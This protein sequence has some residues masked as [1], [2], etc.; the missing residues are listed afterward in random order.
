M[1]RLLLLLGILMAANLF[2]CR[3]AGPYTSLTDPAAA[4]AD[5][6]RP[7]P[8]DSLQAKA[9]WLTPA[10]AGSTKAEVRKWNAS[11]R[12]ALVRAST[13]APAGKV[14]VRNAGNVTEK[15]RSNFTLRQREKLNQY[16]RSKQKLRADNRDQTQKDADLRHKEKPVVKSG[17]K[18]PAGFWIALIIA[19]VAWLVL[20]SIKIRP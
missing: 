15:T 2:G 7:A 18:L 19:V 16:D 10:P 8:A 5:S 20:R 13:A 6:L 1:Y 14:K 3:A 4:S 11:R 12:E 17:F 9:P